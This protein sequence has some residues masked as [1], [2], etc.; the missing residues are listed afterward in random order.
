[1]ALAETAGRDARV[2]DLWER[3]VGLDRWR[4]D[5]ALLA[6]PTG[7]PRELG[8]RNRA[9]LALRATCFGAAWP[10][11][12]GCPACGED[13]EF[14]IDSA[15]LAT[16]LARQEGPGQAGIDWRGSALEARAPTVDDL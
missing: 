12:S 3:G 11:R 16:E 10:L 13:C 6:G 8:R 15:A 9:A 1:M 5:D 4:R 14:E 2:L 7:P